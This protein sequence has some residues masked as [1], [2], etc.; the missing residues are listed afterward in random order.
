MSKAYYNENDPYAAQWLR[1]LI[2]TGHIAPGD[3]LPNDLKGYIQCHFFAGIGI[4]SLALR[5]AGWPDDRPVWTGSCP[6]QP[7]STSGKKIGIAD[8]RHLW[9]HWFHLIANQQQKPS[10]IFGEQVASKDGLGWFDLV[11][12]DMENMGYACGAVVTPAAGFGA[13]HMRQRLYFTARRMAD[14]FGKRLERLDG[15]V[16]DGNKSRWYYTQKVGPATTGSHARHLGHTQGKRCGKERQTVV[17]QSQ[18]SANASTTSRAAT[19]DSLWQ[20]ADWLFSRDGKWRCVE[21]GTF[22]LAHGITNRV[23]RLRAYGNGLCLAQ[24]MAHIEAFMG[25]QCKVLPGIGQVWI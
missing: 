18:W 12:T 25:L 20:D 6:C 4:W 9:P 8:E 17:E 7:F 14:T 2:T 19:S 15:Y 1:N 24:A 16:C 22:P 3:V 11:Q 5:Q 23:G 21:P 10:V 13:P